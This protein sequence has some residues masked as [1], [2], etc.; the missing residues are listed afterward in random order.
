MSRFA[1]LCA[2]LSLVASGLWAQAIAPP[3][4]V[5]LY[6]L[7]LDSKEQPVTDLTAADFKIADQGK[8]Q[9]ILLFR[10]PGAKTSAARHSSAS[11]S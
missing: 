5:W 1:G 7:A 10:R 6:P 11:L 3:P 4:L 9:T 2:A 8:A